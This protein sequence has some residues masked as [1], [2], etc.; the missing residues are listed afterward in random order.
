MEWSK[1]IDMKALNELMLELYDRIDFLIEPEKDFIQLKAEE[2]TFYEI[3]QA[4][5]EL[6]YTELELKYAQALLTEAEAVNEI[7]KDKFIED[8]VSTRFH[9]DKFEKVCERLSDLHDT[10]LIQF[11][12]YIINLIIG[13]QE[14]YE[15]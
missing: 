10:D 7:D 15:L 2:Y 9:G 12:C 1:F 8:L 11:A 4:I 5:S 14:D 13:E 6:N 3:L